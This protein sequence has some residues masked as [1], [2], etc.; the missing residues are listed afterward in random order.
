MLAKLG[1][2]SAKSS[3][4][5]IVIEGWID[6]LVA[7]LCEVDWFDATGDRMPAVKEEEFHVATYASSFP[8]NRHLLELKEPRLRIVVQG[9]CVIVQLESF[10]LVASGFVDGPICQAPGR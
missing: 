3:V 10:G 9:G 8:A 6:D 7:V 4:E 2:G 5:V 1:L